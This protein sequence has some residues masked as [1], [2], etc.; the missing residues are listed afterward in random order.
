MPPTGQHHE[1]HEHHE[2]YLGSYFPVE[3]AYMRIH[4]PYKTLDILRCRKVRNEGPIVLM[5][6]ARKNCPKPSVAGGKNA[7]K[8]IQETS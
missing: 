8:R 5:M 1:H 6:L 4:H 3:T 7:Q 2:A